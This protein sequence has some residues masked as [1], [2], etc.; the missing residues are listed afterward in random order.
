MPENFKYDCDV[1][2]RSVHEE[3]ICTLCVGSLITW[4]NRNWDVKILS[5]GFHR[6]FQS[7]HNHDIIEKN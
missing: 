4:Y 7:H 6:K 3:E 1:K 5:Q 2:I